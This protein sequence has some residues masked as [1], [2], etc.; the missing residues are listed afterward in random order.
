MRERGPCN[1]LSDGPKASRVA[2]SARPGD[3]P[4]VLRQKR[5][6]RLCDTRRGEPTTLVETIFPWSRG[7]TNANLV[8]TDI[9]LRRPECRNHGQVSWWTIESD[10][11]GK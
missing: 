2:V 9:S 6:M 10:A 7:L 1:S 11:M 3:V 4:L 8:E 5:W